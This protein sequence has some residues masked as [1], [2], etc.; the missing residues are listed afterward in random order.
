ML[1]FL[2][3]HRETPFEILFLFDIC[4]SFGHLGCCCYRVMLLNR[5]S[6]SLWTLYLELL[7][8]Y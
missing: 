4:I 7:I 3:P 8:E 6:N 2:L 5:S 1:K